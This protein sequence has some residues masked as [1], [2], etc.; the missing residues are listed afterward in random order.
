M[1]WINSVK[2][3]FRILQDPP[4][5]KTD[6]IQSGRNESQDLV[7]FRPTQEQPHL[8]IIRKAESDELVK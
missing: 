1:N 7:S 4:D 3:N 2:S 6:K 8:K 5:K